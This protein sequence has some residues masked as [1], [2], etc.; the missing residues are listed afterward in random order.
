MNQ[1]Q[2][3]LMHF[4]YVLIIY[5]G[6]IKKSVENILTQNQ[7]VTK[8]GNMYIKLDKYILNW[9]VVSTNSPQQVIHTLQSLHYKGL[10]LELFRKVKV[11]D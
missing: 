6:R 7:Q 4:S 11:G 8:K 10:M 2:S 9:S 1:F 5:K 3:F